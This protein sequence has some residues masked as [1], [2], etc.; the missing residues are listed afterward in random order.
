[1]SSTMDIVEKGMMKRK[2]PE[3]RSG[4]KV[5]VYTRVKEGDRERI[6]A[7]EGVV[8]A[9]RNARNRS[10][11]T[12]RK[13]SYGVGVERIFPLYSPSIE[14]IEVL[15]KGKVRKSKLYYLRDLKGKA[16]RLEYERAGI[17]IAEEGE[18]PPVSTDG[19]GAE[20]GGE[21]KN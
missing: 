10:T 14:K 20:G 2:I 4:D 11:F 7:F 19:E 6:Q 17:P 16:A 8:I 5:R 15:Q 18:T 13:I 12:V 1:M 9:K 21:V 3:F